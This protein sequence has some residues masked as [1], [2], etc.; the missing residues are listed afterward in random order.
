METFKENGI[1]CRGRILLGIAV[2]LLSEASHGKTPRLVDFEGGDFE[3][4]ESSIFPGEFEGAIP[5]EDNFSNN[6]VIDVSS[7]LKGRPPMSHNSVAML[8]RDPNEMSISVH[9]IK[10]ETAITGENAK[11]TLPSYLR[12]KTE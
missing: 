6:E 5:P 9:S 3:S 1:M 10:D 4:E 11:K 2:L 7:K 8:P 12:Q